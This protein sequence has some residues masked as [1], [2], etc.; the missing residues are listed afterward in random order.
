MRFKKLRLMVGIAILIFILVV[1]NIIAF[2]LTHNNS[3][4]Q[5][6]IVSIDTRKSTSSSTTQVTTSSSSTSTSNNN[7][8]TSNNQPAQSAPVVY[9]PTVRTRAS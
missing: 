6:T 1:G 9:Q 3:Q 7:V 8:A 4:N 2:G 5:S